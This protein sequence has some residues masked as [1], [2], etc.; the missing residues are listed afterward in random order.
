M[1]VSENSYVGIN[2]KGFQKI[3]GI[4]LNLEEF[5]R[6]SFFNSEKSRY[7]III[8]KD[9]SFSLPLNIKIGKLVISTKPSGKDYYSG[10]QYKGEFSLDVP[11]ELE[12]KLE[13]N[14]FKIV[15]TLKLEE[16]GERTLERKDFFKR[17]GFW[18]EDKSGLIRDLFKTE[19][20][21]N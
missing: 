5:S 7:K 6:S 4:S 18:K 2:L 20:I 19:E 11:E 8:N 9:D 14:E 3:L 12:K 21:F 15:Y 1:E 10:R 16:M 17:F 13:S